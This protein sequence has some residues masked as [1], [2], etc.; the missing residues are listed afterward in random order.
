[1]MPRYLVLII[2][3]FF[4]FNS[5]SKPQNQS[6]KEKSLFVKFEAASTGEISQEFETAGELKADKEIEVSAERQGKIEKIYV[7]EGQYVQAGTSLIK[8]EGEDVDAD[9]LQAQNDYDS[10]KTLYDEGAISKQEL[11]GYET[12]LKRILSQ[13][14]NLLIKAISSGYVGEIKVD[15]GDY[16]NLGSPIMSLVKLYPLRVSYYI[17]EKLI[18]KVKLGQKVSLT[19]DAF[20][21][22]DFLANVSFISPSVDQSTRAVLVRAKVSGVNRQL[23]AN[24]FVTVKQTILDLENVLLVRE[25]AIYLDQGQEYI[26][27]AD[28]LEKDPNASHEAPAGPGP[29][30]PTHQARRVAIKTGLRK[31]GYV[32]IIEGIQEGENIVYAGLTSIYPGAKLVRV[33]EDEPSE[34][35]VELVEEEV[36]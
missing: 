4:L 17:P 14:D 34:I 30:P 20:P 23:K 5:C 25:E 24:Q 11:I 29:P 10:F 26:F 21:G 33:P 32:Q 16:L 28:E 6:P 27:L 2:C 36:K 9:L 31:P 15:P 1:M 22:K 35:A 18:A 13:K 3:S 12:K 7:Y 19:T 8:I